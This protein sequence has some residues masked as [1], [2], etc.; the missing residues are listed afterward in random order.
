[1]SPGAVQPADVVEIRAFRGTRRSSVYRE[2]VVAA[3]AFVLMLELA[4]REGLTLLA[5]LTPRGPHELETDDAQRLA[6]E[7]TSLQA[8][9][10][11]PDL[12]DDLTAFAELARWCG[13][14]GEDSWLRISVSGGGATTAGP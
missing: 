8:S 12:D 7:L 6:H 1:V 5:A 2:H 10:V 3:A 14:A 9:G 11:P 13:R 4:R